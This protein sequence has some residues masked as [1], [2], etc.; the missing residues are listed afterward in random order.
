MCINY[1]EINNDLFVGRVP[2]DQWI[3][4]TESSHNH[5]EFLKINK[6]SSY[7]NATLNEAVV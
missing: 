2:F 7:L 6:I 5:N 4:G 3:V 1:I